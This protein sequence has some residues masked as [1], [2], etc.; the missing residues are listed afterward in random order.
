MHDTNT[1]KPIH[2]LR[3]QAY[4]GQLKQGTLIQVT[5]GTAAVTSH[6][7]VEN[8][9]LAVTT[10]VLPG[11]MLCLPASGWCEIAATSDTELV[12]VLPI[13]LHSRLFWD[14]C[15]GVLHK[16]SGFIAAKKSATYLS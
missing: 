14:I 11:H 9:L 16:I 5:A 12:L 7:W 2:L 1:S 3:G 6:A 15:R 4:Y 10:P 8:A 13:G